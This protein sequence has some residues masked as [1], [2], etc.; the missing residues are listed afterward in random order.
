MLLELKTS[1]LSQTSTMSSSLK[2]R[3]EILR[4]IVNFKWHYQTQLLKKQIVMEMQASINGDIIVLTFDGNCSLFSR[5]LHCQGEERTGVTLDQRESE[6]EEDKTPTV[7]RT[8][9]TSWS[10]LS[11][12]P[13]DQF[14][15]GNCQLGDQ[16]VINSQL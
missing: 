10:K 1:V 13:C 16:F 14:D 9:E 5:V 4:R 7:K 3:R 6:E 11:Y 8:K 12:V 2:M 15:K